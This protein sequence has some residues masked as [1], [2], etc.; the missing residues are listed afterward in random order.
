[1][2]KTLTS[3]RPKN[4]VRYVDDYN[5]IDAALTPKISKRS[6][7]IFASDLP[8]DLFKPVQ[9]QLQFDDYQLEGGKG[10]SMA[11]TNLGN[12]YVPSGTGAPL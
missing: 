8:Q 11:V 5:S 1:M 7:V 4:N 2:T 6:E 3:W 10:K 9:E 12:A